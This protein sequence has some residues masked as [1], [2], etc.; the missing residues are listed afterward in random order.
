L[1]YIGHYTNTVFGF[2]LGV[3]VGLGVWLGARGY[4]HIALAGLAAVLGFFSLFLGLYFLVSLDYSDAINPGSANLFALPI[5]LFF[6]HLGDF[7]SAE[8]YLYLLL[9]AVPLLAGATT[10]RRGR[11]RW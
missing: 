5:D 9:I 1:A 2:L 11:R 8:P 7:F 3:L 6:G 10:Y 4:R